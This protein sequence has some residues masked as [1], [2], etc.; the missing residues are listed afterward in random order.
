MKDLFVLA[1][2]LILALTLGVAVAGLNMPAWARWPLAALAGLLACAGSAWLT[3]Q[4]WGMPF[5]MALWPVTVP[6][7]FLAMF[8]ARRKRRATQ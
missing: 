8:F 3:L 1:S 6:I 4:A 5:S 7:T 2:P